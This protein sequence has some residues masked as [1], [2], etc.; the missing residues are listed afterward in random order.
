VCGWQVCYHQS[1]AGAPPVPDFSSC[2]S[3]WALYI[4]HLRRLDGDIL[5]HRVR[6][7]PARRTR[8]RYARI[9]YAGLHAWLL[10]VP[11]WHFVHHLPG[12]AVFAPAA[13]R[14]PV[15][16]SAPFYC[17]LC[18][19]GS[20]RAAVH[21]RNDAGRAYL[22]RGLHVAVALTPL[23]TDDHLRRQR[24]WRHG[25]TDGTPLATTRPTYLA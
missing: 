23:R 20:V 18:R 14:I 19:T 15:P 16:I 4:H 21:Y 13:S 3:S 1:H 11:R 7:V 5:L 22:E 17:H 8:T 24:A 2:S 12:D 10:R 9:N 6:P 25:C